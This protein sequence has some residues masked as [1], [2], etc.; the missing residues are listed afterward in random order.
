MM[1]RCNNSNIILIHFSQNNE[2]DQ[3][4][5]AESSFI[6]STVSDINSTCYEA[7]ANLTSQNV[8]LAGLEFEAELRNVGVYSSCI[9]EYLSNCSIGTDDDNCTT[10]YHDVIVDVSHGII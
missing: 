5:L 9:Y 7:L 1:V 8:S 2:T 4:L 10:S 3:S 6:S